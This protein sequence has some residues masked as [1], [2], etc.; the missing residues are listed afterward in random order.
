M[1]LTLTYH[2]FNQN[3]NASGLPFWHPVRYL[4]Y[5]AYW[6]RNRLG[7]PL[8][9]MVF[10]KSSLLNKRRVRLPTQGIWALGVK[11]LASPY[12]RFG[13]QIPAVIPILMAELS[14]PQISLTKQIRDE[15]HGAH[16]GWSDS[17]SQR[18]WVTN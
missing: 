18:S 1:F 10:P 12:L 2:N 3:Y 15:L 8:C 13:P 16:Y 4:R 6:S 9:N 17:R 7:Q 11:Y 14:Q 5:V